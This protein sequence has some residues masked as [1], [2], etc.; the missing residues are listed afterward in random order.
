MRDQPL[1]IASLHLSS[2]TSRVFLY[3][4]P[5][6]VFAPVDTTTDTRGIDLIVAD[7]NTVSL[8]PRSTPA[9]VVILPAGERAKHIDI[10]EDLLQSMVS[11]GL[12]R[13]SVVAAVGGGAITDVV[14]CAGSL[15]LR[16]IDTILI[17]TSLLGMVDA[18]IGGKTGIDFGG[19]KNLVGTFAPAREIRISIP[20]LSSLSDREFRSGLA[21]VIKAAL[22]GDGQLLTILEE[23]AEAVLR[24]DLQL[25]EEVISRAVAVKC[26]VVQ[27]DFREVGTRAYLNLGHTFGHALEATVGL[28]VLTHGEA[29][30]WGIARAAAAAE[31]EG[32]G[33]PAWGERTRAVLRRYGYDVSPC[34]ASADPGAVIRAMQFDKKRLRSGLRFVVQTGP[35]QTETRELA[36]ETVVHILK[37]D[38]GTHS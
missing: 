14:A 37:H 17:P 20:Y 15:Y 11:A 12:T 8:I 23:R 36:Q 13:D 25:L 34:P 18:A 22:L 31:Y 19:F 7:Q 38:K 6:T 32:I 28:G 4:N 10:L 26:S 9:P 33:D 35:H 24:R 30:A 29:V 3:H 2:V 5:D 1:E 21:E 27:Q 16:G